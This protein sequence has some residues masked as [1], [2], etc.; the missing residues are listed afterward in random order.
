M[1]GEVLPLNGSGI[2]SEPER[3]E[4]LGVGHGHNLLSGC[5]LL[6]VRTLGQDTDSRPRRWLRRLTICRGL[7]C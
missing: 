4:L 5:R 6:W 7:A 3:P 2:E 1:A